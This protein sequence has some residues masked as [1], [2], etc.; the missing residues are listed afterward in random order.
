MYLFY[1]YVYSKSSCLPMV[2]FYLL[3][4]SSLW[5]FSLFWTNFCQL[6]SRFSVFLSVLNVM[7]Y[8]QVARLKQCIESMCWVPGPGYVVMSSCVLLR[9]VASLFSW[10][11]WRQGRG[12]SSC[13]PAPCSNIILFAFF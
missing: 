4:V 3:F 2:F 7:V 8:C 12:R 6:S 1:V 10:G 5:C 13:V 9:I 11:D